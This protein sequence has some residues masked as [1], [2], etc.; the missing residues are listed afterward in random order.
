MPKMR[1]NCE[2]TG[3]F[4]LKR[5]PKI[6]VFDDCFPGR[7][8]MTD[9]DSLVEINC[10]FLFMEF[11]SK[12][13]PATLPTGQRILYEN[14][15][16]H[17]NFTV[18]IISGDAETMEIESLTWVYGGKMSPPKPVSLDQLRQRFK[19]WAEYARQQK[20]A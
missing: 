9:V 10:H 1:Y 5:R 8:A 20:A 19:E 18:A 3:C 4:N 15:T 16:K 7:I 13:A 14:L 2:K 6:E 11:K 17:L 12:A